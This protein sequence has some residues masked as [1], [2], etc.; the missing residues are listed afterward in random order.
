MASCLPMR[1][2]A[3]FVKTS[4][5]L[6]VQ[7]FRL[8][9]STGRRIARPVRRSVGVSGERRSPRTIERRERGVRDEGRRFHFAGDRLLTK[10]AREPSGQDKGTD[11]QDRSGRDQEQ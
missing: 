7:A 1:W 8:R 5:P 11:R 9:T 10:R 3:T 2:T 6:R 4:V